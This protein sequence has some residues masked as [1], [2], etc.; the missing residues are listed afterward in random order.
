MALWGVFAKSET[1]TVQAC[2]A[3]LEQL[4]EI[5]KLKEPFQRRFGFDLKVRMGINVGSAIVGNIGSLGKKIE[6]TAIGDSINTAS[7]LEGIN[8]TYGSSICVSEAVRK[9][10][11]DRFVFRRLDRVQMKGKEETTEIYELL[12][13]NTPENNML[14]Q[15]KTDFESALD[16]Y[17]AGD[18]ESA[19]RKWENV[20]AWK[21]NDGPSRAFLRRCETH[22]KAGTKKE[23]WDGVFTAKEK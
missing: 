18:F 13:E 23:T 17:F 4:R 5:E 19:E 21:S 15:L 7:R 8:K 22:R 20:L 10:T 12:G 9:K 6:F 1:D 3:A 16:D 14:W 11:G 2:K